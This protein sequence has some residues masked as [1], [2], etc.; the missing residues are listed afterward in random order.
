MTSEFGMPC[1]FTSMLILKYLRPVFLCDCPKLMSFRE[2]LTINGTVPPPETK[3]LLEFRGYFE[4]IL[5]SEFTTA[6]K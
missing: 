4:M 5:A 1:E 6:E 3:W 2:R